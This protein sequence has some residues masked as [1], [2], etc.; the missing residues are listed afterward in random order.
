MNTIEVINSCL[1]GTNLKWYRP[2]V[3]EWNFVFL[4][5]KRKQ[6]ALYVDACEALRTLRPDGTLTE[7]AYQKPER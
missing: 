6:P 3:H 1:T 7:L 5:Y 4:L 2:C